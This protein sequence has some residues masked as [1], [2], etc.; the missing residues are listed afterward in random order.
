MRR[1]LLSFTVTMPC[2]PARTVLL[3]IL[4]WFAF[5]P[6]AYAAHPLITDDAG[7]QGRGKFQFEIDNQLS[8]KK[9]NRQNDD[10]TSTTVKTT[11]AETKLMATYGIVD[12]VDLVLG[13]PYQWQR[14]ETDGAGIA[15]ADGLADISFEVKW[16]F[17]EK[18]GWSMAVK[19][20]LTLPAGDKD[21]GLGTGRTGYTFFFIAT[22]EWEPLAFHAN[23]GYRRNENNVDQRNDIWHASLAAEWKLRK[24]LRLVANAGVERNTDRT[25]SIDPAFILGGIVY[26]L[27]DS[28]DFDLGI[29]GGL[30]PVDPDYTCLAGVTYRF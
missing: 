20:G 11:A 27:T 2:I 18:N 25:S 14:I 3:G 6:A 8:Y 5:I 21:K 16:R 13:V 28:F 23:L 29:K 10:G 17:F 12:N 15:K 30:T 9:D 4:F 1:R 19:P 7:T 24:N 26:S 22:K